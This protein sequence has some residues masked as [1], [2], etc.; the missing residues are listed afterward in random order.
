MHK[1]YADW[2]DFQAHDLLSHPLMLICLGLLVILLLFAIHGAHRG[3]SHSLL[4]FVSSFVLIFFISRRTSLFYAIGF[5]THLLLDVLNKKP[6]RIFY[7]ADGICLGWFYCDGIANRILL[8]SG[9]VACIGLLV[10][11]YQVYGNILQIVY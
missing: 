4:M 3:F 10:L 11:K 7:P 8:L 9:T 1:S 5:L 6:V 2:R